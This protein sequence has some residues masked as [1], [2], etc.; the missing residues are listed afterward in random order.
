MPAGLITTASSRLRAY[1]PCEYLRRE[2]WRTEI[3]DPNRAASYDVVVFQKRYDE[4]SLELAG[5]LQRRGAKVVFDL[6]D[7]HY[8]YELDEPERLAERTRLLDGMIEAVDLV[9]ASTEA[10]AEILRQRTGRR[11]VV[12]DDA[13]E[14]PRAPWH[15]VQRLASTWRRKRPVRLVWFGSAGMEHPPFGLVDLGRI[16]P[17]LEELAREMPLALTVI[18][19]SRT[20]FERHVAGTSLPVAYRGWRRR[21]FPFDLV[22]H[23]I[24]L[25]PVNRNPLTL[26]KTANRPL[27]S[28]SLGLPVV[29]DT[30]PSYEELADFTLQTTRQTDWRQS[31]RAYAADRA[32]ARRHV[33]AGRRFIR[34]KYTRQRVV[35]QWAEAFRRLVDASQPVDL[36]L[37]PQNDSITKKGS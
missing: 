3:F 26:C 22:Q 1:L 19:N 29:C 25:I 33:E 14:T 4:T 28:L 9:T 7:N 11:S 35:A 10:L 12:I 6:C 37:D 32:L 24:V 30:I 13:L 20:L 34:T 23:D 18:S 27:L 16:L 21:T 15:A 36:P 5:S 17:H 2:G 31:V 8:H